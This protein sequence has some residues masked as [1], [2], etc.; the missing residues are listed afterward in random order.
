MDVSKAAEPFQTKDHVQIFSKFGLI[1]DHNAQNWASPTLAPAAEKLD[2]MCFAGWAQPVDTEAGPW[3]FYGKIVSPDRIDGLLGGK[4]PHR[5]N[6]RR[7]AKES[8]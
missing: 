6:W 3:P 8:P 5:W 1:D 4:S 2:P 7:A